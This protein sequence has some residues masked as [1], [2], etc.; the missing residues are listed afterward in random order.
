VTRRAIDFALC[1]TSFWSHNVTT[2]TVVCCVVKVRAEIY[3]TVFE[4]FVG[5]ITSFSRGV[6]LW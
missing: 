3:R 2:V 1:S 5:P 4:Y 6:E